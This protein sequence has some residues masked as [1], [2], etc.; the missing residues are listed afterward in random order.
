MVGC[1]PGIC[2]DIY[3]VL[4]G[5]QLCARYESSEEKNLPDHRMG[6]DGIPA[7]HT[8]PDGHHLNKIIN[9]V[10]LRT[11]L[12]RQFTLVMVAVIFTVL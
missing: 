5:S 10:F 2:D 11:Q 8:D 7:G 6:P 12:M 9:S 4:P 1:A 3:P